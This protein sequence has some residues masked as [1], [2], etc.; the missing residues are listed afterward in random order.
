MFP[1]NMMADSGMRTL[2]AA[3]ERIGEC[4][5]GCGRVGVAFSGGVDS[6]LLARLCARHAGVTLLTVGMQSSHDL[7]YSAGVARLLR[8]T[9]HVRTIHEEDVER[10]YH[11]THDHIPAGKPLSWYENCMAFGWLAEAAAGLGLDTMVTANGID[12]LFC[13]YDSYRRIYDSGEAAVAEMITQKTANEMQM[14]HVLGEAVG[15]R[16]VRMRQPLLED[17]FAEFSQTIPLQ[18]KILGSDDYIRKHAVRRAAALAGLPSDVCLK[19]KKALQYGTK[20]H[21]RLLKIVRRRG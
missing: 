13:G 15:R 10:A 12:E 7:S 16:G 17:S 20:I 5:E 18:D 14:M 8:F 9:H 21:S 19:R 1:P 6:S 4:L 2:D 11:T 3:G